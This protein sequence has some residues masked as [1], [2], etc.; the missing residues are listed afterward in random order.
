MRPSATV[1]ISTRKRVA[2]TSVDLKN[3]ESSSRRF[4][5]IQ[6][7]VLRARGNLGLIDSSDET[8][9]KFLMQ[10]L[11]ARLILLTGGADPV[12]ADQVWR[13]HDTKPGKSTNDNY[14][15]DSCPFLIRI[16]LGLRSFWRIT[17][18][19]GRAYAATEPQKLPF[20]NPRPKGDQTRN[21]LLFRR[22]VAGFCSR[23]YQLDEE[24]RR[25]EHYDGEMAK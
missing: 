19:G 13:V 1:E 21:G 7:E 18:L 6:V 23:S 17:L 2:A 16:V 12:L 22:V 24:Q 5:V 4:C 11:I 25:Q 14:L 9:L 3:S 15:F 20:N 8:R 10:P